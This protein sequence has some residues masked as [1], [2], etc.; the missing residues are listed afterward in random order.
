MKKRSFALCAFLLSFMFLSCDLLTQ[1]EEKLNIL[2]VKFDYNSTAIGLVYPDPDPLEI[3]SYPELLTDPSNYGITINCLIDAKNDNDKGAVFDGAT[4]FLRVKDTHKDAPAAE[5]EI[6]SFAVSGNK[7]TTLT[8]PF[9]LTLDNP[10]F[11]QSTLS[12]IVKGNKIPYNLNADLFFSLVTPNLDGGV[13]TLG[14]KPVNLDVVTDSISTRPDDE[15]I[16]IF[17][18]ALQTVL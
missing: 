3:I 5:S 15:D 12:D 7:D 8:I 16:Q 13:D 10:V 1:V 14:S 11:S 2:A 6:S 18:D 17:T 4:F 9:Q